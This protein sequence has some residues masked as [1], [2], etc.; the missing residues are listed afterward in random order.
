MN[1]GVYLTAG[2]GSIIGLIYNYFYGGKHEYMGTSIALYTLG[3]VF[4]SYAFRLTVDPQLDFNFGIIVISEGA[5]FTVN[6]F[7]QAFF[8]RLMGTDPVLSFG[9]AN[10]IS[11]SVQVLCCLYY[12]KKHSNYT[13]S[14]LLKE[15]KDVDGKKKYLLDNSLKFSFSLAYNALLND[16]FDQTYFVIFASNEP[17]L[18][19][20]TLIRGFGSLFIRFLYMPINSVTYNLYSKLFV[21]S[22]KHKIDEKEKD[23]ILKIVTI[24]KMVIFIYSNLTYFFLIYGYATSEVVLDLL[25]GSKWVNPV[26]FYLTIDLCDWL[27]NLCG[28]RTRNWCQWKC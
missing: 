5:G 15:F 3:S 23:Y 24:V 27:L 19:E 25:F 1:I 4:S 17:F 26:S 28:R 8:I 9:L 11:S 18:G 2:I 21:E 13:S 20:L 14:I 12:T 10:L 7:A 6:T 22:Q 16:F